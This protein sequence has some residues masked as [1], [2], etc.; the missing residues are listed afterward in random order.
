M[1]N[2][3][4]ETEKKAYLYLQE[5]GFEE[6]EVAPVVTKGLSELKSILE[7]LKNFLETSQ[8]GDMEI[9]DDL[10]HA[11]KGLLFQLGNHEMADKVEKLRE[12]D[13]MEKVCTE[14]KQIFFSNI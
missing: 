3:I 13:E 10:L 7:K 9:L 1:K 6:N 12:Y 4:H 14:L 11:L 8:E 5:F 2:L